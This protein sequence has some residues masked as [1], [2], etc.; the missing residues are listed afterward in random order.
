LPLKA[1]IVAALR[2]GALTYQELAKGLNE[3]FD[4]ILRT[5]TRDLS[6]EKT[7]FKI[8]DGGKVGLLKDLD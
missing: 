6:R 5:V 4:S 7:L 2:N 8:V 1:R 3:K